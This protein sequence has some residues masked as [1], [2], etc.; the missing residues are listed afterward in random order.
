MTVYTL[1][2]RDDETHEIV[3]ETGWVNYGD[4]N[5]RDHG[6]RFV[7]FDRRAWEVIETRPPESMPD[8]LSETRHLVEYGYVHDEQIWVDGD[9]DAGPTDWLERTI[10]EVHGVESYTQAMLEYPVEYW[11]ADWL[12]YHGGGRD[13]WVEDD[14]WTDWL[15][16]EGIDP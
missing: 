8:G 15:E 3:P 6:G 14:E 9:P 16:S 5:P 7:R 4:V 2:D 11:V 10:H 12:A 13:D 1:T